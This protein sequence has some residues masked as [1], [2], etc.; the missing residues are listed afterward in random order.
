MAR[1]KQ[2]KS[3]TPRKRSDSPMS[4]WLRTVRSENGLDQ[5]QLGQHV[6]KSRTAISAYECDRAPVP[7]E[8]IAAIR[9]SFDRVPEPPL[10]GGGVMP[11][12]I[13]PV[14]ATFAKILYAGT[15][16]CSKDWG[17]AL[18]GNEERD[19]EV[20]FAGAGRFLASVRGDSCFPALQQGDLTVW[21]RDEAPPYGVIV[22]A[23]RLDGRECTVKQLVRENGVTRLKPVNPDSSEPF[24]P[25]GW[26]PTARLVGVI[27]I[28]DGP[29]ATMYHPPGI[30]PKHLLRLRSE[31]G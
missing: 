9:T 5:E 8:V 13:P 30:Q 12:G 26:L 24:A 22:L 6:G 3:A 29:E 16:P 17:D 4:R 2:N 7:M 28:D 14:D 20:K 25:E 18:A 19:I 27:W 10:E 15:V 23:E 31:A 1:Q 11:L 21:Q